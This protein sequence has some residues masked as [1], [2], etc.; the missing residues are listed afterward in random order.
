MDFFKDRI[1]EE[2]V[3]RILLLIASVPNRRERPIEGDLPGAFDFWFDG[4]AARL[5]TGWTEYELAD[6]TRA[7]VGVTPGLSVVIKFQNGRCVSVT[8][9][10]E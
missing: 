1:D 5:I 7:T 6:G 8:Q 10:K 4:G 2:A 3:A 9:V